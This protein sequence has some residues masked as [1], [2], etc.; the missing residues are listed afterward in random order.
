MGMQY[1]VILEIT[2]EHGPLH[3]IYECLVSEIL[4]YFTSVRNEEGPRVKYL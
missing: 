2:I 4:S 3:K 1:E